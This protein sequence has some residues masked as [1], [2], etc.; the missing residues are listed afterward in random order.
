MITFISQRMSDAEKV[1]QFFC[2]EAT[3]GKISLHK[4]CGNIAPGIYPIPPNVTSIDVV[5][6]FSRESLNRMTGK[7]N[8]G[9]WYICVGSDSNLDLL[10]REDVHLMFSL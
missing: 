9:D 8:L 3:D 6:D 5:G 10:S 4:H 7:S 1:K 2:I